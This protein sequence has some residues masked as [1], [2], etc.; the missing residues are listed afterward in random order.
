MTTSRAPS[1]DEEQ[2]RAVVAERAAA[3]HDRDAERFV[4]QYA[5]QIVKFD[6][7]PPLGRAPQ[8]ASTFAP[9]TA[10]QSICTSASGGPGG[11]SGGLSAQRESAAATV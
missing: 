2:I 11:A 1:T 5:P 6:L 4:V 9:R 3:M 8:P 10:S 7:A